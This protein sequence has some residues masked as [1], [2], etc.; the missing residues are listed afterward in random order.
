ML[1]SLGELDQQ[2]QPTKVAVRFITQI[3]IL[4]LIVPLRRSWAQAI[5]TSRQE[6]SSKISQAKQIKSTE[7]C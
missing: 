4:P 5:Q 6:D 7:L 2:Q 3:I 1:E